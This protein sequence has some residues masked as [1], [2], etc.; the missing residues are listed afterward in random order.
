MAYQESETV[1]LKQDYAESIRKDII[2]FANTNGG[3]ICIGVT[4]NGEAIGV[5][6]PDQMIQRVA[7]M[8][9]DSIMPD[10]SMFLHYETEK[11]GNSEIVKI[12]VNRG[13]RRPYYCTGKGM[14]PSGVFV[15]QGTTSAP[16]TEIAIRQMIKETD[17][18]SYEEMRSLNQKLSFSYATAAFE[19]QNLELGIPQMI[20]LGMISPDGIYTNLGLLLSDQCPHIIKAAA[21]A[22]PGQDYFLDRREFT[23]SLLRQVDDAYAFLDM[24]NEKSATFDGL[25]R[26]D[27]PA[28]PETA[29]REALLNAVIH[30]DYACSASTLISSYSDRMEIISAGGLVQ[31]FSLNDVMM[32]FSICRN[33]G[34][35]NIFY[36]L[37]L[38]EAYGTGLKKILNSYSACEPESIF[39]VTEKVFKVTLPRLT[40]S[41]Q[42]TAHFPESNEEKILSRLSETDII[43][44]A[45]AEQ[46]TGLSTA[47]ASRLLKRLVDQGTLFVT[48]SGKNTRY[49]RS[50]RR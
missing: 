17:G 39:Q 34:L 7:N 43:S 38:I 46:I 50:A 22:G 6:S 37:N 8:V 28:Y 5:S 4:D 23:G 35:A 1:E 36:R 44:R 13:T 40:L 20:T 29:L 9:R 11:S 26:I 16:A 10:V 19:K 14:T 25:H 12:S 49:H 18:D 45:E 48:G 42:E 3:I 47:S 31:G 32:G 24:R 27:R 33:P 41:L 21:F 15:R 2:A 30:R